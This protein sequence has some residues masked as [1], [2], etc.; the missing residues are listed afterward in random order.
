VLVS[1]FTY[2]HAKSACVWVYITYMHTK[3]TIYVITFGHAGSM[4]VCM[5]VYT[6]THLYVMRT[7]VCVCLHICMPSRVYVCTCLRVHTLISKCVGIYHIYT[8][9]V[10][11]ICDCVW[12]CRV[13]VCVHVC[14]CTFTHLHATCTCVYVC[15]HT[16]MQ[17]LQVF[18]C[19]CLHVHTL[20]HMCMYVF[21]YTN[22]EFACVRVHSY[23]W[24]GTYVSYGCVLIVHRYVYI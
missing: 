7:C 22:A 20:L 8:H 13:Y 4:C 2:R 5:C 23:S 10:Y 9:H 15:S 19:A 17:S 21:T 24:M 12:A 11:K 18:V 1:V 16:C 6:F 3:F 14:V